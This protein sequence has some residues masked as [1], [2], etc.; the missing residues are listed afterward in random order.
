[1]APRCGGS[2]AL[3]R[4]AD[5]PEPNTTAIKVRPAARS[6]GLG[7]VRRRPA[8][9]QSGLIERGRLQRSTVQQAAPV[10]PLWPDSQ[11]V[12]VEQ[13]QST[14]DLHD[15]HCWRRPQV[16]KTPPRCVVPNGQTERQSTR[17]SAVGMT[18]VKTSG[19]PITL[20]TSK[21]APVPER[22]RTT[23]LDAW[24]CGPGRSSRTRGIVGCGA[25]RRSLATSD[26]R[27]RR[28]ARGRGQNRHRQRPGN[29]GLILG[30]PFCGSCVLHPIFFRLSADAHQPGDDQ[31]K[32]KRPGGRG[33]PCGSNPAH[34]AQSL[35]WRRR[36]WPFPKA[37][38][39]QRSKAHHMFVGSQPC[40]VCGQRPEVR[41]TQRSLV[42]RS[43]PRSACR[44][45]GA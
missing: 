28:K 12:G 22:S 20:G 42:V 23:Q 10:R 15:R 21:L 2:A 24:H 1:M 44:S 38:A 3:V 25:S 6:F 43:A 34:P 26:N 14:Q 35:K 5:G 7:R 4:D 45:A 13:A 30:L 37:P 8:S 41:A 19:M 9:P 29:S 16:R 39:R 11:R 31:P 17:R 36:G 27:L 32:Q 18:K 33:E 40:L